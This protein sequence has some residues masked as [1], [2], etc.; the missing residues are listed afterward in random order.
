[1]IKYFLLFFKY[2]RL[3]GHVQIESETGSTGPAT[4]PSILCIGLSPKHE[5]GPPHPLNM[6]QLS[7]L[8]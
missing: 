5:H 3:K 7:M 1:M 6:Q 2:E 4:Y 8:Y